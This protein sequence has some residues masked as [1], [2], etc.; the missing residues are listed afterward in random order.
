MQT[1]INK[2][3]IVKRRRKRFML[4]VLCVILVVVA[5]RKINGKRESPTDSLS[6]T[7]A[8]FVGGEEGEVITISESSVKKVFEISELSTADYTY[9]AIVRAYAEDET[10]I[11]YYVAYEGKVKAGIDFNNII[12]DI[13][14]E[15][16]EISITLPDVE[17]Q[18]KTVNL[19]TMEYIFK[20]KTAKQKQCIRKPMNCVKKIW[21]RGWK[22]RKSF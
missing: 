15:K 8:N 7:V 5:Y 2:R 22:K 4:F 10:T 3:G 13:N 1:E 18:E 16:K 17:F 20:K 11:R 6:K 19:G 14:N 9:N 21:K 12:I